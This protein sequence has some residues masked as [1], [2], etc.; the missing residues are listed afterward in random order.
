MTPTTAPR[1]LERGGYDS[2]VRRFRGPIYGQQQH[3]CSYSCA[4]ADRLWYALEP[5]G[6]ASANGTTCGDDEDDGAD[7]FDLAGEYTV[8]CGRW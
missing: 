6:D 5:N 7:R 2:L 3:V 8:E 1:S 4:S